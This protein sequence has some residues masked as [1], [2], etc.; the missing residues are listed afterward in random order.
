MVY[1]V[2]DKNYQAVNEVAAGKHTLNISGTQLRKL[3]NE[4]SDVP[5]WFSFPEVVAELKKIY[6]NRQ[7]QGF[8]IFLTGLSGSG[9]S[10]IANALGIK[11]REIQER[12]ITILDGDIIR[13]HLSS[14]LGFSK[15]HRSLN[16]RRVG[17]VAGEITKNHGAAICAMIAPYEL[18]RKY[19]RDLIS[20][21]GNYIEV[22]VSTPL[23]VCE[24]RDTK[25]LYALARQGKLTGF[26]GVDDP[27]EEPLNPENHH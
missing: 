21:E 10:T 3:L 9:K 16:V 22:Y 2:E 7:K 20:A 4:G 1:V 24:D 18:D 15:E 25:Q 17:F 19:N 11:L 14:E 27:Y 13:T 23:E 6:P 26:T 12:P 8:T 5:E